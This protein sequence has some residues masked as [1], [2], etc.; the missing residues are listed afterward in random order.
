M[1]TRVLRSGCSDHTYFEESAQIKVL[2]SIDFSKSAQIWVLSFTQKFKKCSDIVLRWCS[3]WAEQK[4]TLWFWDRN[5]GRCR[6]VARDLWHRLCE[7]TCWV[8]RALE[9]SW[10]LRAETFAEIVLLFW[11]HIEERGTEIVV[12]LLSSCIS[13]WSIDSWGLRVVSSITPDSGLTSKIMPQAT[14]SASPATSSWIPSLKPRPPARPPPLWIPTLAPLAPLPP[15]P[16]TIPSGTPRFC[17][18]FP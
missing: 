9:P 14:P 1:V 12:V 13:I 18:Q 2:R 15:F 7:R 6:R 16:L 10:N 17:C 5:L 8:R 3:D 11:D 4:K